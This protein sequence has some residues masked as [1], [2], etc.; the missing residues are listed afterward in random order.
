MVLIPL[1]HRLS[2]IP[3][4]IPS[5]IPIDSPAAI[6]LST[7]LAVARASSAVTARN[8]LTFGST[9]SMCFK[10]AWAISTAERSLLINCRCNSFILPWYI[11]QITLV[12]YLLR[13]SCLILF[14]SLLA[15][16]YL[17]QSTTP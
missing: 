12:L 11:Y 9:A 4:G 1:V 5:I 7:A 10:V 14:W 2:L 15:T 8:A 17:E 13:L 16:Y 6:L 3:M